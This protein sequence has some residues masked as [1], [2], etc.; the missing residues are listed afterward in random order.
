MYMRMYEENKK[1][2]NKYDEERKKKDD[3]TL[4]KFDA[5]NETCEEV[6]IA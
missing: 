2:N 5:E 3:F 6:K 4:Y 1:I